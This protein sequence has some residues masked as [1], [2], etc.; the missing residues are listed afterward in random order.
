M[1]CMNSEK[2]FFPYKMLVATQLA[3]CAFNMDL[4]EEG[5]GLC[6][7]CVPS[8]DWSGALRL[9]SDFAKLTQVFVK[10]RVH[11]RKLLAFELIYLL[12]QFPKIPPAMLADILVYV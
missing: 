6:S 8:S 4:D 2:V 10:R 9:E 7:D 1:G 12:R 11:C 3:A 5:M